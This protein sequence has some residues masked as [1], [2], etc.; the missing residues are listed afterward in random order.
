MCCCNIRQ[1]DAKTRRIW[2]VGYL[3]L[4]ASYALIFCAKGFHNRHTA[5][6]HGLLALL[7]GLAIN[8]IFWS[9][10]RMHQSTSRP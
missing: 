10:R 9:L 2:S 5:L 1:A 6:Y 4:A 8:L 7:M 3:C